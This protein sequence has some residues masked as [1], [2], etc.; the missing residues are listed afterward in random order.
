MILIMK[1]N[2]MNQKTI[3]ECSP[4]QNWG[5]WRKNQILIKT[6]HLLSIIWTVF[7]KLPQI[8]GPIQVLAS[9]FKKHDYNSLYFEVH[10]NNSL[11]IMYPK[12]KFIIPIKSSTC[13]S[14]SLGTPI[15]CC[16]HYFCVYFPM[17][18]P[19]YKLC[20]IQVCFF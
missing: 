4:H 14:F 6:F 13:Q 8:L 17:L 19:E 9:S 12:K 5:A 1:T 16:L 10:A 3:L 7:F 18:S 20:S 15:F 11:E 2:S